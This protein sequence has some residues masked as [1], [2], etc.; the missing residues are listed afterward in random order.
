MF[1]IVS[2]KNVCAELSDMRHGFAASIG[3]STMM[4]FCMI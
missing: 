3:E 2:L 1:G 4:K